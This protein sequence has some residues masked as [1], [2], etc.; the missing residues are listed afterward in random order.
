MSKFKFI[1]SRDKFSRMAQI[2]M[3]FANVKHKWKIQKSIFFWKIVEKLTWLWHVGTPSWITGTPLASWQA[4]L[5]NW[6]AF[7]TLASLMS[8]CYVGTQKW[9]VC[10]AFGTL[11]RGHLD[12]TCRHDTNGTRFS[13]LPRN[14]IEECIPFQIVDIDVRLLEDLPEEERCNCKKLYK[15]IKRCKDNAWKRWQLL[16]VLKERRN[17]KYKEKPIKIQVDD[18]VM[19][20]AEEK[21]KGKWKIAIA[22]ELFY[23]KWCCKI[24]T[25]TKWKKKNL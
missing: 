17:Q 11:A 22:H 19:I 21:N 12:H 2:L 1:A 6:L 15:Y 9:E 3:K 23:G 25:I 8:H 24:G 14:Q 7:G 18:V 20:K 13:K 5:N 4:K 16:V 10:H